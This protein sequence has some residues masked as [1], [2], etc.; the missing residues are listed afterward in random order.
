[1]T[2]CLALAGCYA[3]ERNVTTNGST[4]S[5]LKIQEDGFKIGLLTHATVI[6]DRPCKP[7]WVHF[8]PN[9]VLAAFT[10]SQPIPFGLLTIRADTWIRQDPRGL[11][12]LC[13]FPRAVE[14][15]G[16]WCRGTGG[17]KGV[18]TAFYPG[19]ALQQFF[20]LRDVGIDGVNCR[21]GL[22][23]GWVELHDNGRLKSCLLAEDLER[24]GQRH[25]RGT[26]VELD[27]TGRISLRE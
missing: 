23:H 4:F 2:A 10:A 11:I 25:R 21:A 13:A 14:V 18:S 5:Q 7:G 24:E 6:G 20:P 16:H 19:G 1:M 15:Q 22:V 12:S 17:P 9:G 27:V 8:H 3:W 26:R